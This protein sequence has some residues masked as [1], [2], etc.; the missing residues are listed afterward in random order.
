MDIL[1]VKVGDSRIRDCTGEKPGM[2]TDSLF[3]WQCLYSDNNIASPAV[4]FAGMYKDNTRRQPAGWQAHG[5]MGL[6]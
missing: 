4:V 3:V 2:L 6:V 5:Q 1:A